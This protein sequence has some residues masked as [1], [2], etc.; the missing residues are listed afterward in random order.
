MVGLPNQS[1]RALSRNTASQLSLEE[2][3]LLR[4]N[5]IVIPSTLQAEKL[6]RIHEGH[7]GIFKCRR[8]AQQSVWWPGLN[9][10][11]E[12][13]MFNCS[14]CVKE[15]VQQPEP[16]LNS[17]FPEL[18]QTNMVLS[19]RR[20]VLSILRQ[21]NQARL[22]QGPA[23]QLQSSRVANEQVFAYYSASSS[24]DIPTLCS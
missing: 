1:S 18:L 6:N 4:G 22:Y 2:G 15:R 12:D 24:I 8:R 9:A 17:P 21:N 20:A 23:Q 5:R 19:T 16:L 3:L 14:V 7:Q 13:L 11:L 10:Q